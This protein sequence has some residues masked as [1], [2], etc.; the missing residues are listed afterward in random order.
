M[1]TENVMD[2]VVNPRNVGELPAPTGVGSSGVPG[3]GPYT[4][5]YVLVT[6]RIVQK[7]TYQCNGCPAAIACASLVC[8]L[9]C[10]KPLE[11]V[12]QIT[13]ED[14]IILLGGLP[15]GKEDKADMAVEALRRAVSGGR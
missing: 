13:K 14:V 5:I 10:G 11:Y 8:Q 2:H 3:E 9:V 15:E 6:D 12:G 7:A 1:F 4:T